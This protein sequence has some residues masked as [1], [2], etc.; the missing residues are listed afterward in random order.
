MWRAFHPHIT[1]PRSD[2]FP[3]GLLIALP[4]T[5]VSGGMGFSKLLSAPTS[6]ICGR[7]FR[8][9]TE[10]LIDHRRTASKA[11]WRA[12]ASSPGLLTSNPCSGRCL[13]QTRRWFHSGFV[14]RA[15]QCLRGKA[16]AK[17]GHVLVVS[18]LGANR[19]FEQPGPSEDHHLWS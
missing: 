12:Q 5:P 6:L 2:G 18:W 1:S 3:S 4:V 10:R 9:V 7:I 19:S 14:C 16:I 13:D 17:V 11:Y 8:P 15:G